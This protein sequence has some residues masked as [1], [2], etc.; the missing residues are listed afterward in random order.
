TL[1]VL[2]AIWFLLSWVVSI[3]SC[4]SSGR[5]GLEE[6]CA[7]LPGLEFAVLKQYLAALND[8]L[9]RT[10]HRAVL[11]HRV[12]SVHMLICGRDRVLLHRIEDQHV[13]I[14][15]RLKH[16]L[17]REDAE[18]LRRLLAHDLNKA[19]EADLTAVDT[20]VIGHGE[21]RLLPR[22]TCGRLEDVAEPGLLLRYEM[23]T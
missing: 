4:Q 15:A 17:A 10:Q 5:L 9:G 23:A 12:V 11:V 1:S 16:T 13:A 7:T 14:G 8:D 3:S 2:V 18:Y 22:Q 6:L 19:A 21:H 20:F